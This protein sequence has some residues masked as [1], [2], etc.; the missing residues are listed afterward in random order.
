MNNNVSV[1]ITFAQGVSVILRYMVCATS[2]SVGYHMIE[3]NKLV[4][5]TLHLDVLRKIIKDMLC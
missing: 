3:I 5:A 2:L 1:V 4:R